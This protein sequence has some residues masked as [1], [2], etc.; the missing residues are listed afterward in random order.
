MVQDVNPG[1]ILMGA[2][3][4]LLPPSLPFRFFLAAAVFHF[5]FWVTI[6]FSY[7][8][9]A[10]FTGGPGPILSAIHVLT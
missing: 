7:E 3:L 8:D 4:R 9:V 1:T 2:Q 5:F 6:G 10:G